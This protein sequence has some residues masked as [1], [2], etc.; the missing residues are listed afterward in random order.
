MEDWLHLIQRT[1]ERYMVAPYN[2]RYF[3]VWNELKGYYNPQTN[4]NDI[5]TNAGDP[6]GPNARHGYTY[7]YNQVYTTLMNTAQSLNISTDSIKVGGPYVFMDIWSNSSRISNPSKLVTA[8][9]IFDQ[10]PL[11]AIQYWLQHKVGAGFITVDG[12]LQDHNGQMLADPFVTATLFADTVKWIRSLNPTLFPGST[13]LPVWLAEWFASPPPKEF[14]I[15]YD[16][17]VK[18]LTMS[19]FIKA[20]GGAA[21][22]WGG[23][24]DGTSDRGYWTPTET[25]SGGQPFPWYY[26]MKT[27]NKDFGAGTKL[28]PAIV[29][30]PQ[31]V[32][33][34]ASDQHI[35]LINKTSRA[36][37][38][39]VNGV[40]RTLAAYE[41]SE[42]NY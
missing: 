42:V 38:L 3:Q 5:T 30:D 10:R 11:D 20:G 32:A 31:Q 28:Y 37:S 24:G 19:T 36:L 9:G 1:A 22:S 6:N 29:S 2:V 7:M 26:T 40:G 27:L 34:L 39:T 17:A 13:T 16:N 35:L 25:A 8:Y 33:A 18:S 21:F 41:V 4:S 12:S 23:S 14:N 15:N